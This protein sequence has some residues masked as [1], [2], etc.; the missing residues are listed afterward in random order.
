[1]ARRRSE[2]VCPSCD[3]K[4]G[5][6]FDIG[7][8]HTN[9]L[10][11]VDLPDALW[12]QPLQILLSA[13]WRSRDKRTENVKSQVTKCGSC[14]L[15]SLQRRVVRATNMCSA[16]SFDPVWTRIYFSTFCRTPAWMDRSHRTESETEDSR[17]S[18][19]MKE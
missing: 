19:A 2:W 7:K 9:A 15:Q 17:H 13:P 18:K 4:Y 11:Q 16:E 10:N 1:M 5:V 14:R 8:P 3:H 12:H 6:L